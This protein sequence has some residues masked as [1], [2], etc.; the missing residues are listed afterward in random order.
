MFTELLNWLF[1]KNNYKVIRSTEV[2]YEN[3][4]AES[5]YLTEI[6]DNLIH[7]RSGG[8]HYIND[9]DHYKMVIITAKPIGFS[10]VRSGDK[11]HPVTGGRLITFSFIVAPHDEYIIN[12]FESVKVWQEEIDKLNGFKFLYENGK[13]ITSGFDL[14]DQSIF[15]K[16]KWQEIR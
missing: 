16:S 7:S 4:T 11:F 15:M 2:K 5:I 14:H 1:C 12:G 13:W 8:V 9:S 3:Y 10:G 6:S